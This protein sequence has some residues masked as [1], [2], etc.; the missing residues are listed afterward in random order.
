MPWGM[1][2]WRTAVAKNAQIDSWAKQL[3]TRFQF[4]AEDIQAAPLVY[5]AWIDLMGA[6]HLMATSIQKSAN[7]LARLHMVATVSKSELGFK[8]KTIAINDGFFL[9]SESRDE[10]EAIVVLIFARLAGI[11]IGT[12][13]P[14]DRF[15]VRSGI[16]YGA[17]YTA[18]DL[19]KGTGVKK[20]KKYHDLYENVA[21]G[22]PVI[23]A[24]K[25]ESNAPPFGIAIHESARN[26][27]EPGHAPFRMT[28]WLWWQHNSS[29]VNVGKLPALSTLKDCLDSEL[30]VHFDWMKATQLFQG[31]PDGKIEEWKKMC[32]QYFYLS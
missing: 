5:V 30:R 11:F 8:G 14:Q 4:T 13:R 32:S 23:H 15:L 7:F 1:K 28:H 17:V 22:P 20:G 16:A 18:D 25:A 6:G 9:I 31:L 26:F 19:I 2:T 24:Y 10:I 29:A 3:R 21:F 27:S 12:P